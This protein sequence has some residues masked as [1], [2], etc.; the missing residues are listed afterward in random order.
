ME[1]EL[2]EVIKTRRSIR[3]F[4]EDPLDRDTLTKLAEAASL[5]P[6][7]GNIQPWCFGIVDD[8]GLIKKIKMF[9]PGL[10]GDPA[11]IFVMCADEEIAMKRAEEA[12]RDILS[13]MDVMLATEN[14][15]LLAHAMG[16]GTCIIRSFN[17]TGVASLLGLPEH[18]RIEILI[19]LGR[20]AQEPKQP[21]RRP[22]SE[23]VFFNEWGGK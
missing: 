22:L 14:I 10:F 15:V 21:V 12:G 19:S 16:L 17:I 6:T 1:D 13:R 5:A 2:F 20:P 7:G 11:A 18:M 3:K 4:T 23:V 9:S 8:P